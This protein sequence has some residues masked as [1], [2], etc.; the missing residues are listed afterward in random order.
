MGKQIHH[1]GLRHKKG[2]FQVDPLI[3]RSDL[4]S[5][6][7]L[8][9]LMDPEDPP[10]SQSLPG[11]LSLVNGIM[12]EKKAMFSPLGGVHATKLIC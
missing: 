1:L 7:G 10:H 4:T 12:E 2:V 5:S 11:F 6:Q 3:R 8:S 9:P